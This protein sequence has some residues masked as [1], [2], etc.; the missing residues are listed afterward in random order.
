M[1]PRL[2]SEKK[3]ITA[4][5]RKGRG[6]VQSYVSA[7]DIGVFAA[8]SLDPDGVGGGVYDRLRDKRVKI[9]SVDLT[10]GEVVESLNGKLEEW[11]KEERVELE[12]LGR[13]E[14]EGRRG[15]DL[16]LDSQLFLTDNPVVVDVDGCRGVG[17]EL[18]RGGVEGYWEREKERVLEAVGLK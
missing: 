15:K 13:E 16:I 11:G 1:Y 14:A 2:A 7:D 3:I 17:L 9:G 18:L 5:P 6:S 12:N 10:V 8:A 4:F